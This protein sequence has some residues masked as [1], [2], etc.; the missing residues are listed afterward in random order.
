MSQLKCTLQI[1]KDEQYYLCCCLKL[2]P[3]IR[4]LLSFT[5]ATPLYITDFVFSFMN[6]GNPCVAPRKDILCMTF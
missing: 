2:I 6:Q 3:L 5:L 4:F 1:E